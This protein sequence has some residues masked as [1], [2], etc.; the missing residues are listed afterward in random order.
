MT[1]LTAVMETSTFHLSTYVLNN[2]AQMIAM[3]LQVNFLV[4]TRQDTFG[5][6]HNMKH[7]EWNI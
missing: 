4:G 5:P 7:L 6:T 3:I 2:V 1:G